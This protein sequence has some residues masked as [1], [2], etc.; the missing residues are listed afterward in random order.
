M[1]GFAVGQCHDPEDVRLCF[2]TEPDLAPVAY[3]AVRLHFAAQWV[4]GQVA[5]PGKVEVRTLPANLLVELAR[6]FRGGRPSGTDTVCRR[7]AV[8]E[9]RSP[10]G[11]WVCDDASSLT[12]APGHPDSGLYAAK[13]V[14]RCKPRK[15]RVPKHVVVE[16]EPVRTHAC[17]RQ[18]GSAL[19][20]DAGQLVEQLTLEGACGQVSDTSAVGISASEEFGGFDQS[21]P[22]RR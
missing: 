6:R 1:S 3:P 10:G 19:A 9:A 21:I 20:P 22:G 17:A 16:V 15:R 13:Q 8:D 11:T 12:R 18:A 7:T 2:A 14:R 5:A 4:A